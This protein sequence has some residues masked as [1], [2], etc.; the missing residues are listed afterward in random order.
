MQSEP[1]PTTTD[2]DCSTSRMRTSTSSSTAGAGAPGVHSPPV[3]ARSRLGVFSRWLVVLSAVLVSAT[4][5]SAGA[6]PVGDC[7]DAALRDCC[8]G[9]SYWMGYNPQTA[10]S[11]GTNLAASFEAYWAQNG[12]LDASLRSRNVL[13]FVVFFVVFAGLVGLFWWTARRQW[14]AGWVQLL[15]LIAIP[16]VAWYLVPDLLAKASAAEQA[17][18]FVTNALRRF[19]GG[20]EVSG[21]DQPLTAPC[22]AAI[23]PSFFRNVDGATALT[24]ALTC[25]RLESSEVDGLLKDAENPCARDCALAMDASSPDG[26]P[27]KL[28]ERWHQISTDLMGTCQA[29]ASNWRAASG[30]SPADWRACAASLAARSVKRQIST[31]W[32]HEYGWAGF[33]LGA[34][35][36]SLVFFFFRRS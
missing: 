23:W 34:V 16:G 19:C 17:E 4:A 35:L 1:S 33:A 15:L 7:E 26:G 36:A 10:Q 31:N 6:Q 9:I 18:G 27:N 5:T 29:V 22:S 20:T 14:I 2:T 30:P 32:V 13:T 24:P 8:N 28:R 11:S 12:F 21:L 3:A 25:T